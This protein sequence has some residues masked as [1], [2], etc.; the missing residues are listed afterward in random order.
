MDTDGFAPQ[1][2]PRESRVMIAKGFA[3]TANYIEQHGWTQGAY[4][5]ADGCV[6]LAGAFDQIT[7]PDGPTSP[8]PPLRVSLAG[9]RG[10]GREP[11]TLGHALRKAFHGATDITDG[12]YPIAFNDRLPRETGAKTVIDA[13]RKLALRFDPAVDLTTTSLK[14]A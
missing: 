5:T 8:A 3:A 13:C 2:V 9:L 14:D 7:Y 4:Q 1:D 10:Y 6:C 12:F 11:A